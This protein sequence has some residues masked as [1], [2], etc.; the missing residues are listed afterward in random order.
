MGFKYKRD[1]SVT[2]YIRCGINRV[3]FLTAIEIVNIVS[4]DLFNLVPE[5]RAQCETFW[6]V[7]NHPPLHLEISVQLNFAP[8]QRSKLILFRISRLNYTGINER[9]ERLDAF[10]APV[11]KFCSFFVNQ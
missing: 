10:A 11:T 7:E 4:D 1:D 5:Y 9:I 3:G 6:N 2:H 8:E